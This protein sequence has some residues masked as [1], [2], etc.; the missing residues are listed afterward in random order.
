MTRVR[1]SIETRIPQREG[2]SSL[3]NVTGAMDE[4]EGLSEQGE[5][6]EEQEGAEVRGY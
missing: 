4:E 3:G 6:E 1:V 2:Y 5:E